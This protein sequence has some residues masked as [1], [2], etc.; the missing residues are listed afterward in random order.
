MVW[1]VC[2]IVTMHAEA[3]AFK[4]IFFNLLFFMRKLKQITFEKNILISAKKNCRVWIKS[5]GF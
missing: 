5:L 3:A 2:R 1:T 4:A